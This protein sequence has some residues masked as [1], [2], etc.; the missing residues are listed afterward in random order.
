MERSWWNYELHKR[1]IVSFSL[2]LVFLWSLTS[3][4]WNKDLFHSG[5]LNTAKQIGAAIFSPDLSND[6]LLLALE[7]SLTTLSYAVAGMSLAL[8]I[9]FF[10]GI[11][12][13][14]VLFS[15]SKNNRYVKRFFRGHLGF[16]R[17]IHELVWAWLFVASIGLSPFAAI[18]ALAIPYG[19]ILGKIFADMLEDVRTEPI[20]ALEAA[21]AGKWQTLMYGYLP[22]VRAS[23]VSYA[24]YR[25]ECAVRSSAIMSFV[26]IGGLGYQIQLSLDDLQYN[27]VWTFVFFL[28]FLVLLI[29]MW[30]NFLRNQLTSVNRAIKQ[31]KTSVFLM[32]L[33]LIGSWLS[34]FTIENANLSAVFTKENLHYTIQFFK[35]LIGIGEDQPAFLSSESWA[36]A[37]SLTWETLLMSIIATGFATIAAI[38]TMVPAARNVADGSLTLAK[39][40]HGWLSFGMVRSGY[41]FTRAVPEL[42]WAMIIIFVFKPGILPGAIALALHNYG[43]L[44]KLLAEVIEDLDSRPIRNLASCG[45]NKIQILLLGVLPATLP[46]FLTYILYRWEVIMRTTIVVGFVGAGGL[47]QQFKLSMSFFHYTDITLFLFFYLVLVYAADFISEKVRLVIK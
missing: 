18:F 22:M 8:V 44:G 34:I 1:K 25:F 11:L 31:L 23:I 37:L 30:S 41:I 9:A 15:I 26:G 4:N 45:A 5:G 32:I 38:F 46:R 39:K 10:W 6:I 12:A 40:W 35:G 2:L 33:L 43:I 21:G 19:G 16:M 29:D 7:S 14:G 24:M 47:G 17:A 13:S 3:I 28:I 36:N 27:Q 42:I 20:K